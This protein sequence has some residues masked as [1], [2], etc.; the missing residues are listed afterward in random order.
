[1]S[2]RRWGNCGGWVWSDWRIDY[3]K[4]ESSQR[5][6]KLKQ[7]GTEMMNRKATRRVFVWFE[8]LSNKSAEA[9]TSLNWR[10]QQPSEY[11]CLAGSWKERSALER[12]AWH[13]PHEM[14]QPSSQ[15]RT[16]SL[17]Q[18]TEVW[19]I[20]QSWPTTG[21]KAHA[22]KPDSK[23]FSQLNIRLLYVWLERDAFNLSLEYKMFI[24]PFIP[25]V[26]SLPTSELNVS[27]N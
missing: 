21:H 16:K 17:T 24:K 1:M 9:L 27:T 25:L 20:G 12:A 14:T 26:Y 6:L 11:K 10:S 3:G 13:W 8:G 22:T 4:Q 19:T 5:W 7:L 15:A 23:E 2:K 18:N